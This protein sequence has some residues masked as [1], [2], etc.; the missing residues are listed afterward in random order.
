VRWAPEWRRVLRQLQRL[1]GCLT[2]NGHPYIIVDDGGIYYGGEFD[3]GN[4]IWDPYPPDE[5][6]NYIMPPSMYLPHTPDCNGHLVTQ[7][8]IPR[9]GTIMGDDPDTPEYTPELI[10]IDGPLT[11]NAHDLVI[12]NGVTFYITGDITINGTATVQISA[13]VA[14]P[15][16]APALAGVLIYVPK[17]TETCPDQDIVLNGTSESYFEGLIIAPCANITLVGTGSSD[18]Y[19]GQ[20]IGWNVI[21]GGEADT[22]IIFNDTIR[23]PLETRI[24]LYR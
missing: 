24:E 4:A 16:P 6:T 18:T 15:D 5:P 23:D 7:N 13:P 9:D 22:S 2:G 3:P 19:F 1:G 17:V 20:I 10:C 12:G 8:E 21:V 14:D 11:I